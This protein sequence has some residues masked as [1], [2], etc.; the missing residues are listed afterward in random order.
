MSNPWLIIIPVVIIIGLIIYGNYRIHKYFNKKQEVLFRDL[1]N[2]NH[3][4]FRNIT[5]KTFGKSP[6]GNKS[7]LFIAHV[8]FI[9]KSIIV[10]P[11]HTNAKR[12]IVQSQPILQFT[13]HGESKKLQGISFY[14][15][16]DRLSIEENKLILAYVR[17]DQVMNV[18]ANVQLDFERKE[19]QLKIVLDKMGYVTQ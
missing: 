15:K 16:L 6:L 14:Q 5:M 11:H 3:H 10:V 7:R 4:T 1:S 8:I 19:D 17:T 9:E 13:T 12:K 18:K 2:Y